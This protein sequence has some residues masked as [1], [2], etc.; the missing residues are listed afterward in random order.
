M[1]KEFQEPVAVGVALT[2]ECGL[3]AVR[4]GFKEALKNR[5]EAIYFNNVSFGENNAGTAFAAFALFAVYARILKANALPQNQEKTIILS[6]LR[7]SPAFSLADVL[8]PKE[9]LGK[10]WIQ[11]LVSL[12]IDK[13][14]SDKEEK[15]KEAAR[16][17]KTFIDGTKSNRSNRP[18]KVFLKQSG[19]KFYVY[20]SPDEE[21]K[22]DE[23]FRSIVRMEK[24]DIE[25]YQLIASAKKI[26]KLVD[27][28]RE[29]THPERF[30]SIAP[31]QKNSLNKE[32]KIERVV[33]QRHQLILNESTRGNAPV[34]QQRIQDFE[35]KFH[36][37]AFRYPDIF[38][39]DF[40]IDIFGRQKVGR[41]AALSSTQNFELFKS[42]A[43]TKSQILPKYLPIEVIV[44]LSI[45]LGIS[46]SEL[47]ESGSPEQIEIQALEEKRLLETKTGKK[48]SFKKT[49]D[50]LFKIR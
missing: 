46:P 32:A 29:Y 39:E 30:S 42:I 19:V 15:Q 2:A 48:W 25:D 44:A 38:G 27:S 47:I 6:G 9:T 37:L 24:D 50:Y 16:R 10:K 12:D 23:K 43:E 13:T 41:S 4:I 22:G 1:D 17:F 36:D 18:S 35:D 33:S 28:W 45:A 40:V 26:V 21:K 14:D 11:K 5:G 49:L 34:D 7:P 3:A 31:S 20:L 8:Q